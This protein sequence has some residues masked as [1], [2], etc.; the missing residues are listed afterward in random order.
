MPAPRVVSVAPGS[1]ALLRFDDRLPDLAGGWHV[2]LYDNVWGTN[3]PMW[4][5]QV[6]AAE[7]LGLPVMAAECEGRGKRVEGGGDRRGLAHPAQQRQQGRGVEVVAAGRFGQWER[8]EPG[9]HHRL[10]EELPAE[11]PLVPLLLAGPDEHPRG[12]FG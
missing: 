8:E 2:C 9:G 6:C 4:K 12:R 10:R 1:P 7:A 11:G 3:F 5:W